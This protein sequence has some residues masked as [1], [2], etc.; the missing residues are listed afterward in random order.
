M[1]KKDVLVGFTH[2][3]NKDRIAKTGNKEWM[4]WEEQGSQGNCGWIKLMKWK[5]WECWRT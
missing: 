1:G 5:R 3:V 2:G 4:G